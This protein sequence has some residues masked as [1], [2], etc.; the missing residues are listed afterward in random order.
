LKSDEVLFTAVPVF[1][2]THIREQMN[3]LGTKGSPEY[4]QY[5]RSLIF[6]NC[7]GNI[8]MTK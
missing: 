3:K 1:S 4:A 7:G 8:D 5:L 2:N 6:I